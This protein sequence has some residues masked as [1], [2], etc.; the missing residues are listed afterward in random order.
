MEKGKTLTL[1]RKVIVESSITKEQ[2]LKCSIRTRTRARSG[3]S[4]TRYEKA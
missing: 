1:H 4:N 3:I 2:D